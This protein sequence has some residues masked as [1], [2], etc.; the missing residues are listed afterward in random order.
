MT[1]PGFLLGLLLASIL[2]LLYH[3]LRG[4]GFRRLLLYVL[5]SWASFFSGHWL[6]SL[7]HWTSWRWGSL[8]ILPALLSTLLVLVLAD[9][10]A[11]PHDRSR[12]KTRKHSRSNR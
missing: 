9:V 12:K 8:N 3:L 7:L 10:L 1:L 4:G 5:C 11:G 2:G 6:G